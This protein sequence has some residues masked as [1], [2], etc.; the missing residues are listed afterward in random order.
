MLS[1]LSGGRAARETRARPGG[2]GR[3][4]RRAG[5]A[6]PPAFP[7]PAAP[8]GRPGKERHVCGRAGEF[9]AEPSSR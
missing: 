4:S 2:A 8:T 9:A 7:V 6:P 5:P 1:A 3:G